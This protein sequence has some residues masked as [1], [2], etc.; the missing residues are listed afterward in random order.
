LILKDQWLTNETPQ[1]NP[2][3]AERMLHD[4]SDFLRLSGSGT[5]LITAWLE[6]KYV[7]TLVCCQETG[8]IAFH[9]PN[10]CG[11]LSAQERG[12]ATPLNRVQK[13]EWITRRCAQR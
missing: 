5:P 13:M 10:V 12:Y 2:N 7:A 8:L 1:R 4:S 3:K 6:G 11:Y 9:P